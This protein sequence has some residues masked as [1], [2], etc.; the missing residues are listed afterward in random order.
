LAKFRLRWNFKKG[1]NANLELSAVAGIIVI[2]N[3]MDVPK[4]PE[5]KK[6]ARSNTLIA[7]VAVILGNFSLILPLPLR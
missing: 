4:V 1:V 7:S 5:N 3:F 2:Y 6:P